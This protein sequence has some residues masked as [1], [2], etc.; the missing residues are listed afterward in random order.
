MCQFILQGLIV[1]ATTCAGMRQQTRPR[2]DDQVIRLVVKHCRG[3]LG[4]IGSL[5]AITA[6]LALDLHGCGTAQR[7]CLMFVVDT[8]IKSSYGILLLI[9]MCELS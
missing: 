8:V 3:T 7:L 4:D 2:F 5:V 9:G 6:T 1:Y